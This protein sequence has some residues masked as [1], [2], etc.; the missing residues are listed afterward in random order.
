VK[1]TAIITHG[2]AR[3]RMIG[4]ACEVAATTARTRVPELIA[5]ALAADRAAGATSESVAPLGPSA[6]EGVAT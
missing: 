5:E 3:R 4:Y 1:G 2:R 6:R